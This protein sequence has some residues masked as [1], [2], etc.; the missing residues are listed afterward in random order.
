MPESLHQ[1]LQLP[2][3]VD[4]QLALTH[5]SWT[6]ENPDHQHNERLEYL[7]DA[8]LELAVTE[9]LFTRL[10][11]AA[12]G[13]LSRIRSA[14]V[15]TESLAELARRWA[16]GAHLRLGRGEIASGGRD[17]ASLLANAVEAVLG[18]VFLAAGY[19]TCRQVLET[20][21][22]PTID[23][24]DDPS[25]YGADPKSLLQEL[26]VQRWKVLPRYRE[27]GREGPAHDLVFTCQVTVGEHVQAQGQGSSKKAAQRA[28]ARAALEQ[29][30]DTS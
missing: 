18:A 21:F 5:R 24:I 26:T 6:E 22:G 10:P 25:T 20:A 23:A 14:L 16:L 17:K 12:E 27:L 28:A 8:V 11:E 29:V 19:P 1:V 30:G 3:E 7:G 9:L 4:L 13:D 2:A 15:R